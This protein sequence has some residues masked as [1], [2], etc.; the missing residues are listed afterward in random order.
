[1]INDTNE[2][3]YWM[4]MIMHVMTMMHVMVMHV[5]IDKSILNNLINASDDQRDSS[6]HSFYHRYII[7]E[8]YETQ[9]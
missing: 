6:H 5:I 8:Q 9:S 7:N 4:M 1:M 2:I 3:K